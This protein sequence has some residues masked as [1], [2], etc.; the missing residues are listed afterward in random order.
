LEFN[1]L[2]TIKEISQS[3]KERE[4]VLFCGAGISRNS[5][6]PIADELKEVILK[7]L[8][9]DVGDIDKII[10]SIPFEA[11]ME[12][13]A[14]EDI[15]SSSKSIDI[16]DILKIYNLG[17]INTNHILIAKLAKKN[18]L[19]MIIT[20]NF[21][22]LIE[23]AL[24]R[25]GLEKGKDFDVYY[26]ENQFSRIDFRNIC[27]DK[28]I[29][30]IKLH[31]SIEDIES[32]RAITKKVGCKIFSDKRIDIIR[33]IFSSG[34]HKQVL[35]LG[36]S[37]SDV[38]D[39]MP[40]VHSIEEKQKDITLIDHSN[41]DEFI[42]CL[43][44]K[45]FQKFPG[46]RVSC[47]AD[48]FI[49]H[50]WK[51]F[52]R[53][54]GGYVIAKS[55][56]EWKRH[57]DDWNDKLERTE[58][59]KYFI[60][61]LL[62]V[63]ASRF[64]KAIEYYE[65]ALETPKDNTDRILEAKCY[66]G[67]GYSYYRLEDFYKAIKFYEKALKIV[68]EL[69]DQCGEARCYVGLGFPYHRLG[70]FDKTIHYHTEGLK[71]AKDIGDEFGESRCYIGLGYAYSGL[72]DFNRAIEYYSNGLRI[73]KAIGDKYGE[74]RCYNGLGHAHIALGNFNRAIEYLFDAE[75]IINILEEAYYLKV[76]YKFLSIA[77]EKSGDYANAR[78]YRSL[79]ELY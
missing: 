78:K 2:N 43:K 66:G 6:L 14:G 15:I 16:S 41:G 37:C 39:I 4:L 50:L 76:I 29:I 54:L 28:R 40:Q 65:K 1:I 64:E 67:L 25:E 69:E 73:A 31:G 20:T 18:Y 53:D 48:K 75:A 35:I 23:K 79:T 5:G 32:I 24:E 57:V 74:S 61:G 3:I 11:F 27:S 26:E 10:K 46:K 9:I 60:A 47:N 12:A 49:E 13:I 42:E 58:G 34:T 17:E 62:F 52:E 72:R 56:T 45:E 8:P 68:R 55:T 71:I 77:Y 36:Y 7:N 21:D 33:Y 30:I 22:L 63:T 44:I 51:S 38:F 70:N 59:I 19:K